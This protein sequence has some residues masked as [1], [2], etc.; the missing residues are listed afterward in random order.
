MAA[1]A[2]NPHMDFHQLVADLTGLPRSPKAG[3]QGNA[4]ALNLG[5]SFGMGMGRMAKEMG[6]PYATERRSDGSEWFKAGP[7]AEAIFALYHQ[8]VPGVKALLGD[9]AAVAR[10]RGF[11]KTGFGRRIRFPRG[12]KAYK[13]G[14]MIFQGT[15]ADCLKLKL[16]EVHD[17]L[18]GTD[19]RLMVNV[20]DEFDTSMPQGA[21]SE[22]LNE[23]I[24]ASVECFDGVNCPLKLDVPIRSSGAFG[25]NWWEASK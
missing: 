2:E 8:S 17:I 24:R 22:R 11:V 14:A 4:K 10:N 7:E 9:M 18:R 21:E 5:L 23:A 15:A 6:L 13:A 1:Y 19:A 3:V 20:H 25:E 12:E 16:I